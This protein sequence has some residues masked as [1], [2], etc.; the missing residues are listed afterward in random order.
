HLCERSA[1]GG[2]TPPK[3][4]DIAIQ[5]MGRA[6]SFDP[7]TDPIARVS[8]G[9]HPEPLIAYFATEGRNETLRLTIPKG[10]YGAVFSEVGKDNGAGKRVAQVPALARFWGSYV[11]SS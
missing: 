10:Q 6:D 2:G 5:A 9:S 4:Y 11:S 8:I 3:E 1:D 7:R